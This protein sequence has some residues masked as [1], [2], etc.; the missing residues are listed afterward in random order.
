[1]FQHV[2]WV[3]FCFDSLDDILK[4]GFSCTEFSTAH[5][6][7]QT[8]GV[9]TPA[10]IPLAGEFGM[11]SSQGAV[12]SSPHSCGPCPSVFF[13][14]A[15]FLSTSQIYTGL[16]SLTCPFPLQSPQGPDNSAGQALAAFLQGSLTAAH[17]QNQTNMRYSAGVKDKVYTLQWG[18]SPWGSRLPQ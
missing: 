10:L 15:S 9:R 2:G 18:H 8:Q 11:P 6:T 7:L 13:F 1:M 14:L 12:S 5:T 4:Q 17:Q 16:Q 3:G